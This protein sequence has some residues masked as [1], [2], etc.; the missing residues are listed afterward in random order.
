VGDTYRIERELG[1]GGMSRV[2]LADETRLGRKVVIKVL[3]PEMGAGVNVERFEREIQLAAKLQHPHV[4]PLLTAGSHDDLLYY[5]MPYIEGESL[6]V[7]LA[8]EGELPV[9][10]AVAIL[11]EVLDALA[12]A[13]DQG[14]VHRDIKPDNV[15]LSGKHAVVTDFGVAKAVSASTGESSLTSL[16][17]ALGTPAYMSPEQA[18]AN[19]HVDH[20]ADIY[21]VGALAYEML[22]GQPPFAGPNPQAILAA[23][24]TDAPDPTTSR[25][26][27]VPAAL[28]DLVM[29]CLEKLPA[30]RWQGADEMIPHLD[31]MV[32]PTGGMT[33]TGTK[34]V[35]AV[36]LEQIQR[37]TN[38]WRVA[39][40][41]T[42]A[43]IGA[44][45]IVYLL[46]LQLGLP[47]WVV[48]GAVA[49]LAIGLPIML[50]TGHH[51]RRRAVASTTGVMTATPPG[52]VRGLFTWRRAILGGGLAFLGLTA[53][54][55]TYTAMRVMGIGPVATLMATGAIGERERL[56]LAEFEN[57]TAD[58][59]MGP[60]VT[61]LFRVGI[62]QSPVLNVMEPNRLAP[63]LERMELEPDTRIDEPLALEVAVREGLKA[64]I[65]GDIVA[66]G[67]GYAISAQVLSVDGELLTAQQ[68]SARSADEIITAV[69][70]LSAKL[71]ERIG[72]SLRTIRRKHPLE[73]VTT[74][75]LDALTLY[76]QGLNAENAGDD[77]RAVELFAAAI[78]ED[79]TFAMAWRKLGTVLG[80]NFEQRDRAVEA[81][82]KAY[83]YRDRLTD[84]ERAYAASLYHMN[85]TGERERAISAY[86]TLL[87]TYPNDVVALNN[88][89]VMYF[90]LRDYRR[91]LEFYNRALAEDSSR[92]IYYTNV[93]ITYGLVG[94]LDSASTI[95]DLAD[96]RFPGTPQ[97]EL[98]R[99][100]VA[101]FRGDYER[102]ERHL[103]NLAE[104]Q[105]GNLLWRTQIGQW[106][107]YLAT[108]QGRLMAADRHWRDMLAA[109]E[110]RG[111]AGE[112]VSHTLDAAYNRLQLTGDVEG[113]GRRV[114]AALDRYPLD[115][116]AP[117][118]RPYEPLSWY[119]A[120]AGDGTR[121]RATARAF[122]A[123]GLP[124]LGRSFERQYH[125]SLGIT[126]M[127]V[128]DAETAIA[129]LRRGFQ[130]SS[131]VPC[132]LRGMAHAF[133][134][135]S[136]PDSAL[137]YWEA[138][139][140]ST[141]RWPFVDASG[142]PTAYRR[143]G[144]LYEAKGNAEKAL[145]YYNR[146]VELW[147]DADPELQP[148]VRDVRQ[149]MAR[150]VGEG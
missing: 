149:R 76:T 83:E 147:Q 50:L 100:G 68:T 105:H 30:D 48:Y 115:S 56:I 26:A 64:I 69:D 65:A 47:Y 132:E 43:S 116:L 1:G 94:E 70:E 16:G 129:E 90:Q 72:E 138:Y 35:A 19:P 144:E 45:A 123:S 84:R 96:Q 80:N 142:L 4:V 66:V 78:E 85:V 63:I 18:A 23:H 133:D 141:V 89:G 55:G 107:A 25:R 79:S 117:L 21:A 20:R 32:T 12:Y 127:S 148:I 6:R 92:V 8:R 126:S 51:E 15:L 37:Q 91:A 73:Q 60:T 112:Y 113:T 33:P 17:V 110:Q 150:L 145:E 87:E 120:L 42:L 95:L 104:Q 53:V 62:A 88:T 86:R 130:G 135:A 98:W 29:R 39:G 40:L 137:T 57:R 128:G 31:A 24:V 41:F 14:V 2:F 99:A 74:A 146:F 61:E 118:D 5:V 101:F 3:P 54:A 119:Y 125:R 140:T 103:A 9:R 82:I 11:K 10:A 106:S 58:S 114:R 36:Q 143:V 121:A 77:D 59:S 97:V 49:L 134:V 131:C 71:R 124:T 27:T 136:E 108:L 111:L 93:A 139:A 67:S 13:H 81:L 38:P 46:V 52:G 109:T 22:C 44:L 102:T 7:K 75:S 28:N 34:P 122:E